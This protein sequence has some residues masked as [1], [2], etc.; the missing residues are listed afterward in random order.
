MQIIT[1][2]ENNF[3]TGESLMHSQSLYQS[4][5]FGGEL[6]CP[7]Y[8]VLC[9]L[10]RPGVRCS[11]AAVVHDKNRTNFPPHCSVNAANRVES[12]NR[13]RRMLPILVD[14]DLIPSSRGRR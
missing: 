1:T 5:P 7:E 13:K 4:A 8:T 6:N 11:V 14:G 9:Q 3:E 10:P 12:E 2:K